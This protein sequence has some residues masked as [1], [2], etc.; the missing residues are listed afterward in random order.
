MESTLPLRRQATKSAD[1]LTLLENR[2]VRT[3]H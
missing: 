2:R 3:L 1:G